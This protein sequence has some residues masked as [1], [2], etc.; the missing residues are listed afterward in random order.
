MLLLFYYIF[1]SSIEELSLVRLLNRKMPPL[2]IGRSLKKK[3]LGRKR[4]YRLFRESKRGNYDDDSLF[5]ENTFGASMSRRTNNDFGTPIVP[6]QVDFPP[7]TSFFMSV[8]LDHIDSVGSSDNEQ[9]EILKTKCY[10][11][12]PKSN[13]N[14]ASP[15]KKTMPWD[16]SSSASYS[17]DNE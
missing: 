5:D 13:Q 8:R 16:E 3:G 7:D 6:L 17:Y 10:T 1:F 9:Q 4:K 12:E 14:L 2:S 15:E 11:S